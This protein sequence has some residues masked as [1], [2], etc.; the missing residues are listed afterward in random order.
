MFL[1]ALVLLP[2]VRVGVRTLGLRRVQAVLV[3]RVRPERAVEAE[4]AVT[5]AR[6]MARLVNVAAQ[7]TGGTC[8]AQSIVLAYLLARQGVPVQLR[9]G[10]RKDERG[11][12]AHAWV[13]AAGL[14]LNDGQNN[15]GKYAAF[16]RD[17]A[18]ARGSGR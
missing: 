5:L 12:E 2:G 10:V 13:E 1:A 17:F 3:S 8:L 11:F 9:I 4:R 15:A 16:D 18:L 7:Y 14:G 6:R